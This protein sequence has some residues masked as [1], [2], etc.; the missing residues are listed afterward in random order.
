MSV[1]NIHIKYVN[2]EKK[3]ELKS[4]VD[5]NQIEDSIGLKKTI[6]IGVGI[7]ATILIILEKF[8]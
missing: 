7:L 1:F 8:L 6:P 4:K 3:F 5:T 2:N